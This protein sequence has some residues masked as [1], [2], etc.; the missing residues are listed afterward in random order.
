MTPEGLG[1]TFNYQ[2][3]LVPFINLTETIEERAE[4]LAATL[5][6]LRESVLR[7]LNS[8]VN[9]GI[10]TFARSL[11]QLFAGGLDGR[12]F[13][14]NLLSVL[15]R[16]ASTLGRLFIAY[17]VAADTFQNA[18]RN[19][20]NPLDTTSA[21][22]L[23][24]AGIALSAIGGA[25]GVAAR[26]LGRGNPGGGRGPGNFNPTQGVSN[27]ATQIFGGAILTLGIDNSQTTV[28]LQQS[29]ANTNLLY[30]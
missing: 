5:R 3:A 7:S 2:A 21:A 20:L 24:G 9:D 13:I 27:P 6:R 12:G 28:R 8:I 19:L 22:R 30:G 15:S 17:G 26:N 18:L 11:G 23:I 4:R 25:L 29:D 10:N 16:G 1:L 14:A